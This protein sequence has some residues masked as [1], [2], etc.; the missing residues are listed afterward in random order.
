M[1][2]SASVVGLRKNRIAHA[3]AK[4]PT[5]LFDLPIPSNM[6]KLL[7]LRGDCLQAY[8]SPYVGRTGDNHI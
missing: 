1:L 6:D 7:V 8:R 5:N 3:L 2:V 4:Y